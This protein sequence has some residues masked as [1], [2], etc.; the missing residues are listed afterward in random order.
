MFVSSANGVDSSIQ[1]RPRSGPTAESTSVSPEKKRGQRRKGVI[2][3]FDPRPAFSAGRADAGSFRSPERRQSVAPTG[4]GRT[5]GRGRGRG[6]MRPVPFHSAPDSPSWSSGP[7]SPPARGR[8]TPQ[9]CCGDPVLSRANSIASPAPWRPDLPATHE[10][11]QSAGRK[12][13]LASHQG[14]VSGDETKIKAYDPFFFFAEPS[15][16]PHD[17]ISDA[18]TSCNSA[19]GMWGAPLLLM[20]L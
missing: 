13:G 15:G 5:A 4:P 12:S 1:M 17:R 2:S 19:N 20:I 7:A 11:R 16:A 10:I 18:G 9:S 8:A 14:R 6:V 3:H